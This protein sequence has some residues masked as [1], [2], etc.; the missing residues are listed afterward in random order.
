MRAANFRWNSL[1]G[2]LQT[3]SLFQRLQTRQLRKRQIHT[4]GCCSKSAST[5]EKP[6]ASR[7]LLR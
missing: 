1:K 7:V 6:L 5:K 4:L 3:F 2:P